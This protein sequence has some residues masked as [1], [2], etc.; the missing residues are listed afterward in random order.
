MP[1]MVGPSPAGPAASK[2]KAVTSA[3]SHH[4]VYTGSS[5]SP[6]GLGA[7][8]VEERWRRERDVSAARR[9]YGV[10]EGGCDDPTVR[11]QSRDVGASV[12]VRHQHK[13]LLRRQR[14]EEGVED[15]L[16][17]PNGCGR[18]AGHGVPSLCEKPTA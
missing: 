2:N 8:Y 11:H 15:I 14:R 7:Q 9:K 1:A 16:P 5:P 4:V 12:A 6:S 18:G 3:S 17:R 13:I 10:D